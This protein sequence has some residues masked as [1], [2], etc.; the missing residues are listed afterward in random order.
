[1]ASPRALLLAA[2]ACAA[3]PG[4]RG[5]GLPLLGRFLPGASR[6]PPALATVASG[7]AERR[8]KRLMTTLTRDDVAYRAQSAAPCSRTLL[9]VNVGLFALQLLTRGRLT[10]AG[11]KPARAFRLADWPRLFTPVFLH[12]SIV[13]LAVNSYSLNDLGP[14]VEQAFGSSRFMLTYA[15][16]GIAGNILSFQFNTRATS[17]GAS[18]A[19]F[20]LVGAYASYLALNNELLGKI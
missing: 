13:H 20:G 18:G 16:A 8:R 2:L 9:F 3:L 19:I 11:C 12:G 10:A 14:V 1:M 7:E 6:E 15:L 17:V 5:V 4:A